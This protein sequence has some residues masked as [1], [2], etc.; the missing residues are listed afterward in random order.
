MLLEEENIMKLIWLRTFG[1]QKRPK[2]SPAWGS[3]VLASFWRLYLVRIT[4]FLLGQQTDDTSPSERSIL[5]LKTFYGL[6][7]G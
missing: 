5:V 6:D 7:F 4:R 1:L 3:S 2:I